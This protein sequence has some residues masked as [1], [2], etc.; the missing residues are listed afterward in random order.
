MAPCSLCLASSFCRSTGVPGWP[1]QRQRGTGDG[2]GLGPGQR[3]ALPLPL[4]REQE[5]DEW[6]DKR[7]AVARRGRA[8]RGKDKREKPEAGRGREDGG[9]RR[10]MGGLLALAA[11][12]R[13]APTHR[14]G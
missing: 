14:G 12:A 9:G 13:A 1:G 11:V 5:D 6:R 2:W 3:S 10:P 7:R 4:S 8:A